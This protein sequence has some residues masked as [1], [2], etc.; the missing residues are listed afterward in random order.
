MKS[1]LIVLFAI[2]ALSAAALYYAQRHK[3]DNKVGAEGVLNAL[4]DTQR[5]MSRVPAELT[6]VSDEEEIGIGNRMAE[7]YVARFSRMGTNDAAM[8]SYVTTVGIIVAGRARRKLPYRFHYV[9]DPNFINAFALPG[10][11]V[12]IGKGLIQLMKSEDEMAAVLGHEL[13]HIDDYHCVERVQVQAKLRKLPLGELIGLPIEIFQAGYSKEQELEADR[14]GTYLAFMAGYSPL[15]AIHV[16]ET[17]ERL[18]REYIQKAESPDQELSQVAIQVLAGYFRSHPLPQEREAQI[19]QLIAA[20]KWPEHPEKALR[21]L[22]Q[23]TKTAM[24]Q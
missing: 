22:P 9:P 23:A 11:H 20:R 3:T 24:A 14:D 8:Q 4:A 5:E 12:F 13:E 7:N 18:H 6:R 2:L 10:G 16:F 15:G 1:R 21:V 17:F 19:Q